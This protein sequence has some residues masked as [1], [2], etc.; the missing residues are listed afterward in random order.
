[1]LTEEVHVAEGGGDAPIAHR[2]RALM[3]GLGETCPEIPVVLC[4]ATSGSRIALDCT[5]EISE[6]VH[7]SQEEDGGVVTD[8]IPVTF[9]C[10]EF[11]SDAANIALDV[12]CTALA[13]V[14][15]TKGKVYLWYFGEAIFKYI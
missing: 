2:D 8:E 10:V 11:G 9:R 12:C 4:T 13:V 6:V 1:M 3:E 7:V 15:K 14:R 5:I